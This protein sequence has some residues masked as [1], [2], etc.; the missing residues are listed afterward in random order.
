[1]IVVNNRLKPQR[2]IYTVSA[3]KTAL[4]NYLNGNYKALIAMMRQAS[5]DSQVL[6]CLIGRRAGFMREFDIEPYSEEDKDYDR[7]DIIHSVLKRINMR[8]LFKKIHEAKMYKYVVIDF[9]WQVV[10][11]LQIPVSFKAF[12]QH[13]FVYDNNNKLKID[14]GNRLEEIPPET[15]VCET[16]EIP[17]MLAVLRDY[18]LKEF[19]LSVWASFIETFGESIIIGKYPPGSDGTV[20]AELETALNSI[21]RSSRG[22]MPDNTAIQLV[23]SQRSTG[24][25]AS[26]KQEADK[27]ISITILG[28]ENA[29]QQSKGLQVGENLTSYKVKQEISVDDLYDIDEHMQKLVDIIYTRNFGDNRIPYFRTNKAP[30]ID[31]NQHRQVVVDCYE[32]GATILPVDLKKL[33]L[34]VDK[35]Q[36]AL[37]KDM[38]N[39]FGA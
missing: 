38:T 20:K 10:N 1:M 13:Y 34:T 16:D 17:Y 39:P 14:F 3:F 35:D 9:D 37:K 7:A 32:M 30:A 11:G 15:M 12:E 21:A 27:G 29:V 5:F 36:E 31:V 25:H 22:V 2:A 6:G 33:G 19:G 26:F 8:R 18:I 23:E 24:D 28:H 4:H